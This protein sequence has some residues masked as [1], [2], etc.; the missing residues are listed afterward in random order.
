L[1]RRLTRVERPRLDAI[2]LERVSLR[3]G[4]HWALRDV[5]FELR[6]GERWLLSG[7]NGSGKT[8][9]LKLLR[10]DVWPTPTGGERRHYHYAGEWHDQPLFARE[11]IAYL[12][13]ERQ[14]RYERQGFDLRVAEVVATGFT[15]DDLLLEPPSAGQWREVRRALR[16]VGLA[17]LSDR[18]FLTLSNGQRRRVL[19]ARALIGRPDVLLLDEVLNGLDAASRR[20]FMLSLC[21]ASEPEMA[22]VLTTHRLGERPRAITHVARLERGSLHAEV[23]ATGRHST[24]AIAP[25][26]RRASSTRNAKGGA[27]AERGATPLL[28]LRN[29][30]VFRDGRRVLG[31]LDWTIAAGEHWL[32]AGPNGAGKSTL[33]ALLYGDLSPADGGRIE[34]QGFPPGTPIAEWKSGVGIVSPEL[35]SRYAATAC[36]V[37]EI[38]VS[39]LHSSIGLDEPARPAERALARRRLAEV[40][41]RGLGR[42]RAR[43][44]SYGQ[45]RRALVARA[46]VMNRR[47]LLLDEPFDGLDAPARDI[48]AAQVA[49]AVKRGTQVVLATHHPEDVPTY[50]TRC[51]MLPAR[52]AGRKL[53]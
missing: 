42:R 1:A 28:Q 38:V 34:R 11:R 6:A 40:G 2:R 12:G 48:V 32:I 52:R 25:A 26:A 14:D 5:S 31:P 16:D 36:T 30:C 53:R 37:E 44:L 22:W 46:L 35:Q 49:A 21:R 7:P 17:G 33:I 41:L 4:R 43:E 18:R 15:G 29:A 47:L 45:L 10:G 3:L 8:V 19:L 50:V 24:R 27:A 9:L 23:F 20:L 51:L 13:P 39:G